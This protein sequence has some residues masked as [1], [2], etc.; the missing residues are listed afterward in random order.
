[1]TKCWNA[2]LKRAAPLLVGGM[3]LQVGGCGFDPATAAT[4]WLT[5]IANDVI[6]GFVY[7]NFNLMM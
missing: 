5:I 6:G 3:L 7:R 4:E 2:L 1:M